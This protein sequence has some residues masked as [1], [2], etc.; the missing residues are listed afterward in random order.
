MS[1]EDLLQ[2]FLAVLRVKGQYAPPLVNVYSGS[3]AAGD[4]ISTGIDSISRNRC[5]VLQMTLM[6]TQTQDLMK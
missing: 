2:C 3:L 1:Y 6:Q 4:V 5:Y